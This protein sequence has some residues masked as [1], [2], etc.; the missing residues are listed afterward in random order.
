MA[1]KEGSRLA[2]VHCQLLTC[3]RSLGA[4]LRPA[5]L[6]SKDSPAGLKHHRSEGRIEPA[7]AGPAC[8]TSTFAATFS[9]LLARLLQRQET[10]CLFTFAAAFSCLLARFT[11]LSAATRNLEE[12]AVFFSSFCRC[13]VL[14]S[15]SCS[16]PF[17]LSLRALA[18]LL[19]LLHCW[20]PAC[21]FLQLAFF[22]PSCLETSFN[23]QKLASSLQFACLP[24]LLAA[25]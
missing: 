17:L 18:A 11:L 24:A 5:Q 12:L 6:R 20:L 10:S 23:H 19:S 2:V 16:W 25:S 7:A 15:C 14:P 3:L 8:Q 21:L 4:G 1:V 22:L 9:C 13:V